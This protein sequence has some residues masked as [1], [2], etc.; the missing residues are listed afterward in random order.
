MTWSSFIRPALL[1][2]A[3]AS[4]G[5]AF[6]IVVDYSNDAANGNFFGL[7]PVAKAAIDAAAADL[8][9]LLNPTSLSAISPSGS[10]NVDLIS[11][12]NGTTTVSADWDLFYNN[13][14]TAVSTAVTSPNIRRINLLFTLA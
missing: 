4:P 9:A 13:P 7:R 12:T 8:S 10:P 1:S 14:S 2:L 6:N 5:W 3:F 11:H